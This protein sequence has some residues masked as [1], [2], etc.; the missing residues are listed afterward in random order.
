MESSCLY[1]RLGDSTLQVERELKTRLREDTLVKWC[2]YY[3]DD[4]C[5]CGCENHWLDVTCD[6][7]FEQ[8]WV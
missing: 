6:H 8:H 3:C 2:N 1:W 7:Y 5:G 4:G